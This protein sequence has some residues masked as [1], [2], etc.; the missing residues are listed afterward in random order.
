M[1][2]FRHDNEQGNLIINFNVIYPSF[3]LIK[4]NINKL[5][6]LLNTNYVSPINIPNERNHKYAK[7]TDTIVSDD[8]DD[9]DRH[10]EQHHHQQQCRSQ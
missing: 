7:L 4:N 8:N 9:D 2:I 3:N 1:P 5:N 10:H 6:E